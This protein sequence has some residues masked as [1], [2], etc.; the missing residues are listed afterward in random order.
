MIVIPTL[1]KSKIIRSIFTNG[2][3]SCWIPNRCLLVERDNDTSGPGCGIPTGNGNRDF[4]E[5]GSVAS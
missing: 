1:L 5:L 4:G 3:C 2:I